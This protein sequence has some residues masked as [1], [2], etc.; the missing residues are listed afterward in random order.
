MAM[1][2]LGRPTLQGIEQR[3]RRVRSIL[4]DVPA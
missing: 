2:L 3:A 1:G 4:W